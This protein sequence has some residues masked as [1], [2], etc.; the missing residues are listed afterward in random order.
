MAPEQETSRKKAKREQ[1]LTAARRLFL[2]Q[3]FAQTSTE[4]IRLTAGVS[5]ETL[6][7]YYASKEELFADVL[8]QLTLE[9]IPQLEVESL[10]EMR[11]REAFRLALLRLSQRLIAVMMQPEYLALLRIIVAE[12]PR[13]PQLGALFRATVP[14]QSLASLT[15][16]FQQEGEALDGEAVA[17]ML[18]GSLLTYAL[19]DGLLATDSAPPPPERLV[20]IV[21]LLIRA[22]STH[23]KEFCS[24]D[25]STSFL[26]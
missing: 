1:I 9:Q 10:P 20:A 22:I 4:A 13:F 5:K 7:R 23:G 17:R 16:L 14:E 2:Q 18:L 12:T 25:E 19:L 26:A 15:A 11:D 6:Y 3:G 8:Q 21:D 24:H